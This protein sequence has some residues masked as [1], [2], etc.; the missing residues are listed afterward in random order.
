[1]AKV[2]KGGKKGRKGQTAAKAVTVKATKPA[3]EAQRAEGAK[4]A[5]MAGG[6][7][8]ERGKHFAARFKETVSRDDV[9][10]QHALVHQQGACR[11]KQQRGH[12]SSV[13]STWSGV[14]G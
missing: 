14:Q 8:A 7:P 6:I 2:V 9:R 5:K 1:M 4:M 10:L 13:A 11:R 12:T 3:E